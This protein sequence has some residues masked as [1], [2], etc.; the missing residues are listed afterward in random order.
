MTRIVCPFFL[1]YSPLVLLLNH[2][3]NTLKFL[4]T[5][6]FL[7]LPLGLQ[8]QDCGEL[9]TNVLEGSTR[10]FSVDQAV[11]LS[12]WQAL[13]DSKKIYF[14]QNDTETLREIFTDPKVIAISDLK[15]IEQ[16]QNPRLKEFAEQAVARFDDTVYREELE[17]T[18]FGLIEDFEYEMMIYTNE[19]EDL[20]LGAQVS[21]LVKGF[22]ITEN[23]ISSY[24]TREAAQAAGADLLD[25]INWSTTGYIDFDFR[26]INEE[27]LYYEWSG[28]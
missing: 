6:A 7:A 23:L 4:I 11:S 28:W 21:S 13:E 2:G 14:L 8:A 24:P 5:L 17:Q 16:I 10:H 3:A 12:A 20:I 1:G 9:I 15:A 18:E 19:G 22:E 26:V 27:D 25:D